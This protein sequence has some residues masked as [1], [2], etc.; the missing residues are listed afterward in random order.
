MIAKYSIVAATLAFTSAATGAV[1]A[2]GNPQRGAMV[3]RACAAL[4]F[5]GARPAP[6]RSE[7][8]FPSHSHS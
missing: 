8:G 6:D 3:Y 5:A 2:E 7:L 4:S 1:H